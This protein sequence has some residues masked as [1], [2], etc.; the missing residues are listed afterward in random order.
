MKKRSIF[1]GSLIAGFAVVLLAVAAPNVFAQSGGRVS[2]G[3]ASTGDQQSG[4]DSLKISPLRTDISIRQGETRNV[5]VYIQNLTQSAVTL[6]PINNDFIAGNKEDGTPDII[7]NENESAPTHSLKKFMQP[8]PNVTLAPGERKAVDVPIVV[9]QN[10][11]AGGYFGAIRFIPALADG[12]GSVSV[13]GSVAS[14]IL[15]TVP[16]NF[17]EN[18]T[19]KQFAIQQKGKTAGRFSSPKNIEVLLRLENKGNVQIAPRGDIFVQKGDKVIYTTKV[20]DVKPAGMVLPD[21]VRKWNV[22]VEKM[23]N[24]GKYKITAVVSYGDSNKTISTEQTIWI[25]PS[26]Y[27]IGAVVAILLLIGLIFAIVRAL[28]AYKR[29]ILRGARRR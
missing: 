22:P 29:R 19:L 5:T 6:K 16:G 14:L 4:G 11:Q 27:I 10:A 18:L 3:N 8:I 1:A 24:F 12:S 21:S 26:I 17:V 28:Q 20:N 23:G 13:S 2:N 25:I 15:L 7:L 9:P